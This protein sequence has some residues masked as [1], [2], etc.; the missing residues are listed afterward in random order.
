MNL[1]DFDHNF[2]GRRQI[3]D[4]LKKRLLG[5]KEGYRQNV[6]LVGSRYIGKTS[7][8]RKVMGDHDDKDIILLYLDL[9]NRDFNYFI[10][11]FTKT[12]L[13]QFLKSENLPLFEDLKLLCETAR[14]R[15]PQT[16]GL[17][18]AANALS[19]Q[20]K[21]LESY[22]TLLSLADI[23]AHETNKF[24]VLIF[25][26]F[27]QLESFPIPDVFQ[28][29]GKRI[30]TQKTCLYI[31]TSSYEE[32]AKTILSEKL[33]LL[34][35]NFETVSVAAFD[36]TSSQQLIDHN[37]GGIK[38]GLQLKNFLVDFTGGHPLY[39]NILSQELIYLSG[40]YRQEEIYAPIVTQAI[41]SVVFNPWGVI[42][43]HFE[44]CMNDLSRGKAQGVVSSMLIALAEGKHKVADLAL[45][46]NMKAPQVNQRINAL[47]QA[48]IIEKNGNYF[49]IKDKLFRYWIKYVYERR[50]KAVDLEPGR[51][52]KQFKEEI[53]KALN[54]FQMIAR[55]DLS[56][57][58]VDL[59]N[60]FDSESF[61]LAG[62]RY[63]LS[64]FRDITPLKLRVGAG[65]FFDAVQAQ[66]EDGG[67][68]VVLKKDPVHDN[69]LN[70]LL[71]EIKKMSP[72]PQ[73]CVIVSLSGLDDSAKVR[74]LQEKL[75]IWNE[76]ELNTLM[77]LYDE[78]YI[79]R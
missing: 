28:E 52:R 62:R 55:K 40:G 34:F 56:T 17:V 47:L 51:V 38:A 3:L 23:F 29:L 48:D 37:L 63:K 69:D 60:K 46:L 68:L 71:E 7:I 44:L 16:V 57:R 12:L 27:Q 4:I 49:H 78:P 10:T 8:L 75:W 43:R 39:I 58:M 33:S 70:G 5:L 36:S 11:Q 66:G 61:Q 25:D 26:E 31:V 13:Y 79:T 15:I 32:Q 20:G 50:L 74:A 76:E 59:L 65:N 2:F 9:E 73:R 42:S 19:L 1:I 21:H 45:H 41:E 64:A 18:E 72:K 6:A 30:M 54:D 24:T 35:G 53:N 67:W 14:V 22:H 77:H